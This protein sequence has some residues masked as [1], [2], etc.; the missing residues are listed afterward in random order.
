MS[1]LRTSQLEILACLLVLSGA[2][3]TSEILL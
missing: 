3:L 2:R 1:P